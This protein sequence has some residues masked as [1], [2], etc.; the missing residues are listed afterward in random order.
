VILSVGDG[1][2]RIYGLDNVMA[3]ELLEF[4]H[5]VY[6]MVLNLE[7]DNVGAVL[8][9]EDT[10]IREGDTV[11]RTHSISQVPVGE[12]LVGRLA[13]DVALQGTGATRRE[14][15]GQGRL[16]ITQGEL[17]RM[18]AL[19]R[20]LNLLHLSPPQ[21]SAF[22]Q[23]II[24][25]AI[26]EQEVI[27]NE[28]DLWGRGVNIFGSGRIKRNNELEFVL[29]TGFGRGQF[30]HI[31]LLSDAV[32]LVGKQ[33]MRLEVGGTFTEPVVITEPLSPVSA[34]LIGLWRSLVK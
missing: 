30:P 25:Y 2:A 11:K 23:A 17:Y 21:E 7:Q 28:M 20:V 34:P 31:P 6:G 29:Y 8:F 9:G 32:E 4:P 13:G 26:M 10:L 27:I 1:I 5:G 12:E 18:P 22:S 24:D 33:L 14:L 15:V 16:T 19:L 3:G